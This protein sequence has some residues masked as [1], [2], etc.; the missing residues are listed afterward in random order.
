[1]TPLAELS[2]LGTA[3]SRLGEP[4]AGLAF[5][6]AL[7]TG[8]REYDLPEESVSLAWEIARLARGTSSA[9]GEA[10]LFL[11]L[12]T[13]IAARQGSTRVPLP[14]AP[15]DAG[16]APYIE[17]IGARLGLSPQQR[18][19]VAALLAAAR[20]GAINPATGVL[21]GPG[22]YTPL[23]L[24]GPYLYQQRM[25]FYEDR[26]SRTLGARLRGKPLALAGRKAD[27]AM[28]DLLARPPEVAGAPVA[29]SDEQQS[30]VRAALGSA[31]T[32]VSGGP[33][34]GKTSIVLSILRALV[35]LGAPVESIALAAPTGKAANRLDESIRKSLATVK[36][37]AASD[38]AILAGCTKP[39]T[40]HRLLG[41][42]ASNGRFRHH[43]NNRLSEKVVIV[44]ECSMIDLFLMD[45][46]VRSVAP[47]A[48]LILL[49]D[50][51]Q[52]PSV[53]AG[54]VFR[55]LL[56]D[57]P[58]AAEDP[59]ARAV[60]RL[61]KNY[62]M[63]PSEAGGRAI[64]SAAKYVNDGKGEALFEPGD[65]P[66]PLVNER[67]SAEDLVF[68]RIELLGGEDR[69]AVRED[70]LDR[71][72]AE[73]V[74][75]LPDFDRLVK[76]EYRQGVD[77]FSE[78]D[79]ADLARLQSH[80][81]GFR[82]LCVTRSAARPTG[83]EAVN[84]SLHA[85]AL[86]AR[87]AGDEAGP[88]SRPA[89]LPGEPVMMLRNDYDR[90]IFNGDQ[91]LILRVA[92]PGAASHRFMAVFR[93]GETPVAY[94]LDTLRSDLE[95]SYAITVHKAQGSEYDQVGLFLPETDL[96]LLT[97][98]LLYTALTRSRRSVVI[99]GDRRLLEAAAK[100]RI[101]RSSGVGE[102]LLRGPV[103]PE[104]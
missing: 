86:A 35:R 76:K 93:R 30:A 78:A 104:K 20:A 36:R 58:A 11:A 41:F 39:R 91:G 50:A 16:E 85:R 22:D 45:Q 67:R 17:S 71:W 3:R 74:R 23:I 97:R 60:V 47:D 87:P 100:A 7:R 37:R 31:L 77:G 75:G 79:R 40:L 96:P 83:A 94:H 98:E 6:E 57:E 61:T 56:P 42:Y 5:P 4:A 89:F 92:E 70:F 26:L 29:L 32:V 25:L 10:L 12:A 24:D 54:A 59:R 27:A 52:L 38:E 72:H 51:D 43:E 33:G 64:L 34:T 15:E 19:A 13:L 44:D 90:E 28:A 82:L 80:F 18:V 88:A 2:P 53:E 73:R 63:D 103:Q 14:G 95:L 66:D 1:M 68:E 48:R 65:G 101:R 8:V 102:K 21:G 46:L 81:D 84:A 99:L 9:E 62:R 55:D 49:G 69:A